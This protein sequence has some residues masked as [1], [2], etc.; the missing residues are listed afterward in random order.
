MQCGRVSA[1]HPFSLGSRK[2]V[3]RFDDIGIARGIEQIAAG[4][5][6]R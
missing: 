4:F 6:R 5:E 2:Q 3:D 1:T